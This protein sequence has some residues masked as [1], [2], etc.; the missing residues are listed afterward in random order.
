MQTRLFDHP[1]DL[2]ELKHSRFLRLIDGEREQVVDDD[3]KDD[4]AGKNN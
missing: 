1:D 2:S 3:K 4:N